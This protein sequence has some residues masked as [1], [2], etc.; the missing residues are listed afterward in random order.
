MRLYLSLYILLSITTAQVDYNTDIQ[1]IFDNSCTNCHRYGNTSGGLNLESYGM[2]MSGNT[3]VA[4]DHASS[5]LWQR[6][7]NGSMP[8]GN[9]NLT[10]EQI[11]KIVIW[12][13]NE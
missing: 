13:N 6:V 2:L 3:V 1:P 5:L 10:N 7:S 12:I 9:N 4:G 11:D 8:P